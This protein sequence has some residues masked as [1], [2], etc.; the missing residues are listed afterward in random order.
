MFMHM[1]GD[2]IKL[3]VPTIVSINKELTQQSVSLYELNGV[4]LDKMTLFTPE[5]KLLLEPNKNP[6][7]CL[8]PY[9]K[10]N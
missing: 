5:I 6:I 3:T 8:S 9:V 7:P 2:L 10:I 4:F 1:S